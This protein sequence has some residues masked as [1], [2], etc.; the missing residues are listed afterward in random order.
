MMKKSKV[1][2]INMYK[3]EI[4]TKLLNEV[5]QNNPTQQNTEQQTY[6]AKQGGTFKWYIS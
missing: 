3:P 5:A 4:F 2:G 1:G 6:Y